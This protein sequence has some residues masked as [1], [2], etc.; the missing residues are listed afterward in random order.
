[1]YN[2]PRCRSSIFSQTSTHLLIFSFVSCNLVLVFYPLLL[3]SRGLEA[4]HFSL[5]FFMCP[6]KCA[7]MMPLFCFFSFGVLRTVPFPFF[8]T[9]GCGVSPRAGDALVV[10]S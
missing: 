10:L 9:A 1:M 8:E 7:F 3:S 6:K 5:D 4:C 2:E